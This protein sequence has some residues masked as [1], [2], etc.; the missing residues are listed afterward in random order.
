MESDKTNAVE[1]YAPGR[2]ILI[3]G[4]DYIAKVTNRIL[5]H[6]ASPEEYPEECH[7]PVVVLYQHMPVAVAK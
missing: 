4:A 1:Y 3:D 6:I 2:L 7:P 5:E